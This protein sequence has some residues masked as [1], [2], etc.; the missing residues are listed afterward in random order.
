MPHRDKEVLATLLL[1]PRSRDSPPMRPND[2]IE[3]PSIQKGFHHHDES[4]EE[5]PRGKPKWA[6]FL[7]RDTLRKSLL[8]MRAV[9]YVP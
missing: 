1:Y 9:L 8:G 4:E 3:P 2:K 6:T 5:Y 7:K